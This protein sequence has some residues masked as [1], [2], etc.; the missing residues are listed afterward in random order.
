MHLAYAGTTIIDGT[1]L[2]PGSGWQR[3]IQQLVGTV[4]LPGA[5]Y[6]IPEPR[7]N[8]ARALAGMVNATFDTEA[9]AATYWAKQGDAL[10]DTGTLVLTV[11]GSTIATWTGAVLET[12]SAAPPR[13]VSVA[14]TYSFRLAGA[15]T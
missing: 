5:A 14:I 9:A 15:A 2:L 6:S 1:T 11:G 12:V 3:Q 7:G 8:R 13:G 4:Q 10:P